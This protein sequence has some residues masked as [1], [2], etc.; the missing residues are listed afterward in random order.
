MEALT[1]NATKMAAMP[2]KASLFF[3]FFL[4]QEKQ[5]CSAT[6]RDRGFVQIRFVK[7]L[8]F[9]SY[10]SF[11]YMSFV[12][13][14]D[15]K[16]KKLTIFLT[17]KLLH[18]PYKWAVQGYSVGMC[19]TLHEFTGARGTH[20]YSH[21]TPLTE[22]PLSCSVISRIKASVFFQSILRKT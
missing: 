5:L 9:L 7:R 2:S 11:C 6:C 19:F 3:S 13:I 21:A 8:T 18:Y 4:R 16:K 14:G 1:V 10:S 17:L 22:K 15:A 12:V 20:V